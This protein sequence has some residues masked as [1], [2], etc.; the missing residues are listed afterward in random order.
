MPL[1]S[2]VPSVLRACALVLLV[3][4]VMSQGGPGPLAEGGV[5]GQQ[6]AHGC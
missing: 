4:A 1:R 3:G 5:T 2:S 6:W